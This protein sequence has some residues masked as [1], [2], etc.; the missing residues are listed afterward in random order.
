MGTFFLRPAPT[1]LATVMVFVTWAQASRN[2][3]VNFRV[4]AIYG[5]KER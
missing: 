5:Q 1:I 3:Q 4:E 2:P